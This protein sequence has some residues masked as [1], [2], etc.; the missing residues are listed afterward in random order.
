M[1]ALFNLFAEGFSDPTALDVL[2]HNSDTELRKLLA[3]NPH[4]QPHHVDTL[5][6]M[7]RQLSSAKATPERLTA[8]LLASRIDLTK[9]QLWSIL[10][11]PNSALRVAALSPGAPTKTEIN[12]QM[13]RYM[14]SQKW[15]NQS[16]LFQLRYCKVPVSE[17]AQKAMDGP[18]FLTPQQKRASVQSAIAN[19][20]LVTKLRRNCGY[21]GYLNPQSGVEQHPGQVNEFLELPLP[22]WSSQIRATTPLDLVIENLQQLIGEPGRSFYEMFFQIIPTWPGSLTEL[23]ATTRTLAAQP[24]LS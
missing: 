20:K 22:G 6:K 18:Y 3:L 10:K 11:S 19:D 5:F 13:L 2:I 24:A 4:L 1:D 7:T 16:Y 9:E 15:F 8:V 12:L 17:E 21:W 23:V 14:Q